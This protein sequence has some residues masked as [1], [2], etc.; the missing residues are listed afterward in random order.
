MAMILSFLFSVLGSNTVE[1]TYISNSLA[2]AMRAQ[3]FEASSVDRL[4]E[5]EK[6][7]AFMLPTAFW[8][9]FIN[10]FR[11]SA[12]RDI[13]CGCVR[14]ACACPRTVNGL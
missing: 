9:A 5:E 4:W 7:G 3:E 8:R 1:T 6:P 13:V 11:A 10:S 12:A 14:T 2:L